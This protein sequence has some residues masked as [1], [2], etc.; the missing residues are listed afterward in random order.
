M[1]FIKKADLDSFFL[2]QICSKI[3][4]GFGVVTFLIVDIFF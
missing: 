1:N 4:Y 3:V 2:F